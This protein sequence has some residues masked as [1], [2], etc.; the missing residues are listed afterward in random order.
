MQ[1]EIALDCTLRSSPKG[2]VK[3]V[4]QPPPAKG[5]GPVSDLL[6]VCDLPLPVMTYP[7]TVCRS[8]TLRPVQ[9]TTLR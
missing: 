4:Q 2:S 3:R 6:F 9:Y 1:A 7:G 8:T 5:R